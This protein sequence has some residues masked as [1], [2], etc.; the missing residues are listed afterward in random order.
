MPAGALA[1]GGQRVHQVDFKL[2]DAKVMSGFNTGTSA[3]VFSGKPFGSGAVVQRVSVTSVSGSV[4]T[5][6]SRFTIFTTKGTVEGTGRGTRTTNPDGSATVVGTRTIT[7]G[8]GAYRGARG[9]LEVTG[10]TATN[11]ITTSHWVGSVRY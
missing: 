11:G 9:H 3:G 4:V 2:T 10:T 1:V 5:T 8:T 6:T 7:S